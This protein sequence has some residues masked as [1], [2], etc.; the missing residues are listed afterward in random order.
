MA[1]LLEP[2]LEQARQREVHVVA[3]EQDVLADGHALERQIA[4]PLRTAI[5]LKSVV[6]PPMS[7]TSTRSPTS[8]AGASRRPAASSQA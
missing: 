3:A 6:P 4:V 2:L 7:H 8:R 5:R 1:R